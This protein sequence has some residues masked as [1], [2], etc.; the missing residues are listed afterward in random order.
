[1]SKAKLPWEGFKG[2]LL[3]KKQLKAKTRSWDR[4]TWENYLQEEVESGRTESL[5]DDP[6]K[7]DEYETS[8]GNIA[9]ESLDTGK[10]QAFKNQLGSLLSLLTEKEQRIIF[11]IFWK[12]LSQRE[13]ARS[14][15]LHRRSVE[16]S[17]DRALKKLGNAWIKEALQKINKKNDDQDKNP[18]KA[19]TKNRAITN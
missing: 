13:I 15:K 2:Q 3:P 19:G 1:M 12:G 10:L 6:W 9:K 14:L 18:P 4:V 7:I 5:L 8:Y 11:L 16:N 17:R